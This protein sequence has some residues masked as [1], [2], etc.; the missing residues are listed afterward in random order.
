[1]RISAI[2]I[3]S[4]KELA[5]K[6]FGKGTKVFLYGSRVDDQKKGGDIDL[7]ISTANK[8]KLTI[9]SKV[10]YMAELKRIIGDQKIDIVFDNDSLKIKSLFYKTI[11]SEALEL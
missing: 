11:K 3:K 4:I 7:L 2:E 1:M 9:S 8:E 5:L 6:V 10:L